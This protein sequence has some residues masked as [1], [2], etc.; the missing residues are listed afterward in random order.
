MRRTSRINVDPKAREDPPSFA[1]PS[2]VK[3]DKGIFRNQSGRLMTL[4]KTLEPLACACCHFKR[5]DELLR[6]RF[7]LSM[8]YVR[9]RDC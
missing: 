1:A 5:R 3:N 2:A 9:G 6:R 4:D 8:G 7:E